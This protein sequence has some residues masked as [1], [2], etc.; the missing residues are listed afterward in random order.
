VEVAARPAAGTAVERVTFSVNLTGPLTQ[1]LR[2]GMDE[3]TRVQ[4]APAR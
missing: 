3:R 1:V 4:L 2:L